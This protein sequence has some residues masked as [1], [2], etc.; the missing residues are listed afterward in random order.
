MFA[1]MLLS[2]SLKN[3]SDKDWEFTGIPLQTMM[4]GEAFINEVKEY[5]SNGNNLLS[6][7]K[8]IRDKKCDTYF[9]EKIAMDSSKPIAKSE[10]VTY[11]ELHMT[12]ALISLY[13]LNEFNGCLNVGCSLS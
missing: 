10:K 6:F 13:S 4:L 2:L 9:S 5:C 11:L 3:F 8:R 12:S 7:F 1:K